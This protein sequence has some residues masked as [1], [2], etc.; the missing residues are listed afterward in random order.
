MDV[1][2]VYMKKLKQANIIFMMSAL[3]PYI[4]LVVID[5]LGIRI[6]SEVG[7]IWFSQ[8]I[9][10]LP[11]LVYLVVNRASLAQEIRLQKI[12]VSTVILL[13]LFAY[14]ITPLTALINAISLIFSTNEISDVI[15]EMSKTTPMYLAIVSVGLLPAILEETVYRG[16][17]YN[18]YRKVN[19]RIAIVLSAL[20]FGLLHQNLNQ[21]SYAFVLGLIFALV[22]E[23]TNSIVSTMILHFT[24]NTSS[25]VM[26]YLVPK[27]LKIS[28]QL[29]G[30]EVVNSEELMA[31]MLAT[32]DRITMIQ[33]VYSLIVPSIA[34]TILAFYVFRTIARNEHRYEHVKRLFLI[35]NCKY[36]V[37]DFISIPLLLGMGIC[38]FNIIIN[39]IA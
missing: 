30:N 6:S 39:L 35:R 33:T 15:Y 38:I 36:G 3:M 12:R 22:I 13:I 29:V 16:V 34:S 25:V 9:F 21:F 37:R 2:E 28:E 20:L 18:E 5:L 27:F 19:P 32:P 23:A 31:T 26:T 4:A 8:I 24:L 10:V 17:L 1:C 14:L 7:Q 11:T